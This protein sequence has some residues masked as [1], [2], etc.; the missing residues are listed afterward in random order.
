MLSV[1]FNAF[2]S[3]YSS[4]VNFCL[5]EAASSLVTETYR[6]FFAASASFLII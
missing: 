1:P 3:A 4:E 2:L 6:S 5:P